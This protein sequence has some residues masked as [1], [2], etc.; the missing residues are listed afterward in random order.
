MGL[1]SNIIIIGLCVI[2]LQ[3]QIKRYALLLDDNLFDISRM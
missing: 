2:H 1:Q 3:D